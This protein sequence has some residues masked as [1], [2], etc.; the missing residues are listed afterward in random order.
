[1]DTQ[2][3]TSGES[4][5][6]TFQDIVVSGVR[7]EVILTSKRVILADSGRDHASYWGIP[8]EAIGAVLTGEN[9]FHEPTVTLTINAPSGETKTVELIFFRK[10]GIEKKYERDQLVAKIGEHISPS[11]VHASPTALSFSG[12]GSVGGPGAWFNAGSGD[13]LDAKPAP[14]PPAQEW[15][16]TFSAYNTRSP[17]PPDPSQRLKFNAVTV[18]IIL[19]VAV[20]GGALVY[21]QFAKAKP[22]GYSGPVANQSLATHAGTTS[23]PAD[24]MT[25]KQT[26]VPEGSP[27]PSSPPQLLIPASG[28]WVHVQY[29][30][31]FT[32]I[33]GSMQGGM[34]EVNT[35]GEQFYQLPAREGIVDV[36]LQKQEGSRDELAVEVYRDGLLVTRSNTTAPRG[37]VDFHVNL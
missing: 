31:N 34:R 8:F 5:I 33:V 12:Q 20:V 6:L 11:L 21:S 1:M 35:S 17:P 3:L 24:T 25:V 18:I 13:P 15:T 19:I 23:T 16:P 2:Y 37:T 27:S 28:V 30:G 32:G 7:T 29:P 14:R 4:I 22:S 36:T 9:V 10:P 26:T